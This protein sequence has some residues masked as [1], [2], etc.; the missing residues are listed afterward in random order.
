MD[1]GMTIL[2]DSANRSRTGL[3]AQSATLADVSPISGIGTVS[4]V[5]GL[6]SPDPW[7]PTVSMSYTNTSGGPET[8]ILFDSAGLVEALLNPAAPVFPLTTNFG[9]AG[10]N[11]ILRAFYLS[12]VV[13]FNGF[14][15]QISAP[16]TV[17]QTAQLANSIRYVTA[18][19]PTLDQKNL[20]PQSFARNTAQNQF[21]FTFEADLL[22][23]SNRALVLT[24]EDDATV[25]FSFYT[26]VQYN[27]YIVNQ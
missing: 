3:G 8:L 5:S 17:I 19:G 13:E 1:T 20:D 21:L 27:S 26:K 10:S 7:N 15:Y 14:N 9:G 25:T 2:R 12:N 4:K 23:K 16:T 11:P 22:I 18:Q 6:N 24:V